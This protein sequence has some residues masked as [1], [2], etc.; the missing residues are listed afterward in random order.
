MCGLQIFARYIYHLPGSVLVYISVQPE[1]ELSSS[2]R[3]GQFQKFSKNFSWCHYPLQPPLRKTF[4]T[5]HSYLRVRFDLSSSINFR[6]IYGFPR[7]GTQNVIP[8][9]NNHTSIDELSRIEGW[10][11]NTAKSKELIGRKV[12]VRSQNRCH[13]RVSA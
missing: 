9:A 3:F 10:A 12:Y 6:D 1:Y 11:L 8:A 13:H 2:T 4:C 7:L 5:V